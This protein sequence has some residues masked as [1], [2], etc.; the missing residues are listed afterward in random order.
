MAKLKAVYI[1]REYELG[2]WSVSS[3]LVQ[4]PFQARGRINVQCKFPLVQSR[5]IYSPEL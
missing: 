2:E 4:V 5:M 3:E 1:G